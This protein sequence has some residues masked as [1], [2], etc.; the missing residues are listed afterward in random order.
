MPLI[1]QLKKLT[2]ALH[3]SKWIECTNCK[4]CEGRK[5]VVL[6]KG[7]IPC[8]ILFVGEAPGESEDVLGVPFAG[9]S[10]RLLDSIIE[11]ALNGTQQPDLRIAFTNVVACIPRDQDGNKVMAP[12]HESVSACSD[13]LKEF[14]RLAKPKL[15]VCVGSISTE[16]TADSGG[17]MDD[18]NQIH[19]VD[20]IHP[21]AIL[22]SNIANQGL[23]AQKAIVTL[24]EAIEEMITG[25][26]DAT[27]CRLPGPIPF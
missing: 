18:S 25:F 6:G 14:I 4:S 2:F 24:I 8:D 21:A 23:A 12:D 27:V 15:I 3:R 20:I 10:G 9:P 22:R 13:R 7:K 5:K 19:M 26:S 1:G 17:L 11:R 16:Y